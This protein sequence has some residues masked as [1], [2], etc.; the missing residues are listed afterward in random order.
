MKK[1][2]ISS[3]KNKG[4]DCLYPES[5]LVQLRVGDVR[6][7]GLPLIA[8]VAVL[9]A[10]LLISSP[11]CVHIGSAVIIVPFSRVVVGTE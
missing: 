2:I 9:I 6:V 4:G 1:D 3:P 7:R 11:F 8:W 5:F 10:V